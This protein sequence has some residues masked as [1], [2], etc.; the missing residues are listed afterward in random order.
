MDGASPDP[1]L[2]IALARP[3]IILERHIWNHMKETRLLDVTMGGTKGTIFS[4]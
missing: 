4:R 2:A 1:H 3:R